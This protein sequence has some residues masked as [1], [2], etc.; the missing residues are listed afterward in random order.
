MTPA[1]YRRVISSTR[2]A[3]RCSRLAFD[4]DR[5]EVNGGAVPVVEGIMRGVTPA[6]TSP[7]A[8]YGVSND[9]TLVYATGGAPLSFGTLA[10][11]DRNGKAES[12]SERRAAYRSPRVS[13]DG[14]R[15]AVAMQNPDGN[16]DIWMVDVERGT[17]TRLT[18]DP[19]VDSM[20]LWT[21]DGTR[22]VFSSGR[23]GGASALYWMPADGSGAVEELTKA[24]TN[25]GATSWLP[26]S[27]TLA[28]YDVGAE[29]RHLHGEAGGISGA[30]LRDA[31]ARNGARRSRP[32]GAGLRI[33]PMKRD[34]RRYTSRPILAQVAGSRFRP[35]VGVHRG[36]RPTGGNCSTATVGR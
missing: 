28:F 30:V 6:I 15:V 31:L 33:R 32:M 9:G 22:L 13:P 17:H 12:L 16:E 4:A 29:L 26:D 20:P 1:I 5:L 3:I 27:T 14:A 2:W 35:A 23:A 34:K 24:T 18:S 11:V 10:W 19:A 25:Q 7:T 36:G 21:P 8:N